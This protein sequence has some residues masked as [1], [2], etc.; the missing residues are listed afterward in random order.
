MVPQQD[1]KESEAR[2]GSGFSS[3]GKIHVFMRD[4]PW[5]LSLLRLSTFSLSSSTIIKIGGTP[6]LSSY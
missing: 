5:A 3:L 1:V 6:H 2:T 4:L